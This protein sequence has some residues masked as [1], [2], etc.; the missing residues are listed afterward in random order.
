MEFMQVKF[1]QNF[2]KFYMDQVLCVRAC[3]MSVCNSINKNIRRTMDH[4][5]YTYSSGD[6]GTGFIY[7]PYMYEIVINAMPFNAAS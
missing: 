3:S 1:S 7:L 6:H 5:P 2:F 4:Y